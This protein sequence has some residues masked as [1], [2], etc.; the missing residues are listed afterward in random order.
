MTR[1][2]A[3]Q[4]CCVLLWA[5]ENSCCFEKQILLTL[6]WQPWSSRFTRYVCEYF[7][8]LC[9]RKI[10]HRHNGVSFRGMYAACQL[11]GKPVNGVPERNSHRWSS[12]TLKLE[13][14]SDSALDVVSGTGQCVGSFNSQIQC[15]STTKLIIVELSI[16]T[17]FHKDNVLILVLKRYDYWSGFGI[18]FQTHTHI[19]SLGYHTKTRSLLFKRSYF[20]PMTQQI[21]HNMIPKFMFEQFYHN[22]FMLSLESDD[23]KVVFFMFCYVLL[24]FHQTRHLHQCLSL[25]YPLSKNKIL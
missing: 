25:F 23:L 18:G 24:C 17:V 13:L 15:K 2:G 6:P 11:D 10:T 9:H 5:Q 19:F 20:H 8:N 22:F 12:A 21:Y 14:M 3:Q 1:D 7:K 16:G 4:R